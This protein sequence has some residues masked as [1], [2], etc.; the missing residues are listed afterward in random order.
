MVEVHGP[1][2]TFTDY[3]DM[4]A[5]SG[6]EGVIIATADEF[7]VPLAQRAV[8]AGKHVLVEKP[9]G[10]SVEECDALRNI[11]DSAGTVLHVGFMRRYDPGIQHARRFVRNEMGGVLAVKAWY[12]DSVYRYQ[13]TDDLLPAPVLDDHAL[14]PSRTAKDGKGHYYLMTHGCHLLDLA[15]FLGGDIASV[16]CQR[17]ERF[18]MHSW[19]S[20]VTFASG[21]VGQLDL[22]VPV[23]MDWHE[24]FTIYGEHGCVVARCYLPWFRRASDVECVSSRTGLAMRVLGADADP[25]RRQIEG[26]ASAVR[27]RPSPYAATV[28]DGLAATQ[29]L[30]ATAR[31][32]ETGGDVELGQMSGTA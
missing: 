10:T 2:K 5:D 29:A 32:A 11:V 25:Y 19:A 17:V 28:E 24:G 23:A 15:R 18:G 6:V 1:V 8:R 31:A 13:M 26:F 21:A 30:V 20:T 3:D 12:C 9:M 4:L 7:H 16:R 14:R 22:T 27:D